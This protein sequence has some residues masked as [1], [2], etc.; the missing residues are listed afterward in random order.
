MDECEF[1]ANYLKLS[2]EHRDLI[3]TLVEDIVDGNLDHS[4]LSDHGSPRIALARF[5]ASTAELPAEECARQFDRLEYV[6][7]EDVLS[8]GYIVS[9]EWTLKGLRYALARMKFVDS[10]MYVS[11]EQ[12]SWQ[13]SGE[14]P[15]EESPA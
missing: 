2:P 4:H 8:G 15:T 1:P 9:K 14:S 11:A 3:N 5:Q 10:I 13:E 6:V 12:M 7:T